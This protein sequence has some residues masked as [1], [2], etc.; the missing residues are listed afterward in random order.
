MAG[1]K[2]R[3]DR[4]IRKFLAFQMPRLASLCLSGCFSKPQAVVYGHA[5]PGV[6]ENL[7]RVPV[8]VRY[9]RGLPEV[10]GRVPLAGRLRLSAVREPE[11]LRNRETAT[12]AMHWLSVSSL[13]DGRDD[14][15]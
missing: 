10:S 6:S 9:R 11:C 1:S 4:E 8:D 12:L 2:Y 13:P 7:A 14:P 5:A 3:A 15:A